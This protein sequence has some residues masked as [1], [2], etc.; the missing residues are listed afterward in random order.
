MY[1]TSYVCDRNVISTKQIIKPITNNNLTDKGKSINPRKRIKNKSDS[2]S[3]SDVRSSRKNDEPYSLF[4]LNHFIRLIKDTYNPND[5]LL[6]DILREVIIKMI[7]VKNNVEPMK[8]KKSSKEL[9][10]ASEI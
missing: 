7:K 6:K 9:P 10:V 8:K 4:G 2:D 1:K 3:A 5:P